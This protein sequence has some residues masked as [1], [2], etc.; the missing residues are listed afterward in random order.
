MTA[1][2]YVPKRMI[3]KIDRAAESMMENGLHRFYESLTTF[4]TKIQANK[5]SANQS[6]HSEIHALTVDDLRGP[7][8]FCSYLLAF[9]GF[10]F[11]LELAN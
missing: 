1:N 9:I 7:L 11:L 8:I 6:D 10:I 3:N 4:M 5:L 2:E